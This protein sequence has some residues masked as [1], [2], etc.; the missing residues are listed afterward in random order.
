LK[1][2]D[3]VDSFR[4]S[5]N[6]QRLATTS[7]DED[8][9]V[10]LEVRDR[11]SKKTSTQRFQIP[12][13]I[14]YTPY[15]IVSLLS[16]VV[17]S[18]GYALVRWMAERKTQPED[19]ENVSAAPAIETDTSSAASELLREL[20]DEVQVA[21]AV[22]QSTHSDTGI[23][24]NPFRETNEYFPVTRRQMKQ[25]WRYLRRFIREGLPTELDVEATIHQIGSQGLLLKPVL[26]PRRVNRSELILLIDRD[27][28][29]QPF[30]ALSERLVETAV[31]GG[32]LARADVYYFH[33]CPQKYLYHDPY[34][35]KAEEVRDIFRC[36]R[37]STG[38]LICSDAGAARGGLN[39]RRL[40]LTQEF[41]KDI[42]QYVRYVAWINPMPRSR[43]LGTTAGEIAE[44]V[45]MFECNR[46]GLHEAIS[47]LRGQLIHHRV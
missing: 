19:D 15:V 43:W 31:Q 47:V 42:K 1:H 14:N 6:G 46:Q 27:G 34:H 10:V 21:K 3:Q 23:S 30:H 38:V 11:F 36:L 35:Y 26:V 44:L 16:L 18:V 4:I 9:E 39:S 25:S 8:N 17:L 20:D 5:P 29:M 7:S 2:Q 22:Q 28:S 32:R 33:N 40:E 12:R 41:L 45:P 24:R 37:E 13:E